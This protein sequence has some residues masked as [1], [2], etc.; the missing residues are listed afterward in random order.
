MTAEE[1]PVEVGEKRKAEDVVEAADK[2][3]VKILGLVLTG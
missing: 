3:W 2:K 1:V